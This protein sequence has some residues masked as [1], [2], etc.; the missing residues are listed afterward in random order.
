M[1]NSASWTRRDT[2][3]R[4]RRRRRSARRRRP[5]ALR[6]PHSLAIADSPTRVTAR[7]AD[8]GEFGPRASPIPAGRIESCGR[9]LDR[10]DSGEIDAPRH[11]HT[12]AF[13]E[14]P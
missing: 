9:G 8:A 6:C 14:I 5:A 10:R 7:S 4:Q 11:V 13:V 1:V 12:D 3:A 2:F